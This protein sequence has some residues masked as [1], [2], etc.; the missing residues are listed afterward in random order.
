MSSVYK[1]FDIIERPGMGFVIIIKAVIEKERVLELL[2]GD[3]NALFI[4]RKYDVSLYSFDDVKAVGGTFIFSINNL[5]GYSG[6]RMSNKDL[7]L[8]FEIP[9]TTK[10][11]DSI[12]EIRR[13]GKFVAFSI[14]YQLDIAK[15]G[16]YAI[17]PIFEHVVRILSDGEIKTAIVFYTDEI[18]DL[19]R[20]LKYAEY[21]RF[22]IPIPII[23]EA[24]IDIISKSVSELKNAEEALIKGNYLMT[25]NIIRNILMNYLTE[26]K[27]GERFLR[28]E[29][30]EYVINNIPENLKNIYENVVKGIEA[31]LR[32]NLQH[33][34]KFIH[35]DT[36]KLIVAPLREDAEYIYNMLI[37]IL[38]YT[39]QLINIW[40][41]KIL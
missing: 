20:R 29:L 34:H 31:V 25:L 28:R 30:K 11:L 27:D 1:G 14:T 15:P 2:G 21:V 6:F 18:D 35:E 22:E 40:S 4:L 39:S 17:S 10:L 5:R 13:K 36:G 19:M 38:R 16:F 26:K 7:E 9:V 41:R 3:Y 37:I 12:N 32:S 23:P 24:P 8:E 33:I